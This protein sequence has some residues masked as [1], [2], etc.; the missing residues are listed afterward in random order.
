[1]MNKRYWIRDD[2]RT[3]VSFG[4]NT[5][6]KTIW[7]EITYNEYKAAADAILKKW[8]EVNGMR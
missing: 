4:N 3:N 5:L 2:G 6:D 1:M 8:A 7:T